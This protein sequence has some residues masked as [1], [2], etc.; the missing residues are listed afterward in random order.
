M[1]RVRTTEVCGILIHRQQCE[2]DIFGYLGFVTLDHFGIFPGVSALNAFLETEKEI[3]T[4]T[5]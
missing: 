3:K 1:A 5:T 4:I 2:A